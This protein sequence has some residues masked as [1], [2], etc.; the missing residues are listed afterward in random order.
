MKVSVVVPVYNQEV[1]LRDALDSLKAQTLKDI[2]FIIVNDGSTDRSLEIINEYAQGDDRFVVLDQENSGVAA[3]IN[4]GNQIAK[5]EYL[6]EM[7]SDDY[8]AHD[9][10]EIMYNIA[11]SNDLDILKSNVINFTGS[12]ESYKGKVEKIAK[13][14]YYDRVIDP[15]E[16][17][18]VFSFPMYAWVSLYRRT[19]IIDNDI[20]WNDGVS[21]YNDNGFFWQTMCHAKRVMYLDR[22]FIYHRRDNEMSTV[23]NPDKMFSNFFIEHAF[24]KN[25]LKERGFFEDIKAYFFERKINNYYFALTVIPFEKKREFFNLIAKDF[26]SD[27]LDEGLA[28]LTFV[29]KRNLDKILSICSDPDLYYSTVYLPETYKVSVVVPIHNAEGF[30]RATLDKLINQSLRAV[31]FILVE[32]GSTDG[33]NDIIAEYKR[34]DARITAV[35]IGPSN[36]GNARNVGLSMANGQY[37]IFLDAD[38]EYDLKMLEK[39]H[40]AAVAAKAD[41]VW[42]N[43][44]ERNARTGLIKP[45]T[46]AYRKSNFPKGRP[47]AFSEISGNPF[48][49]MIGWPWDKLY[50]MRYVRSNGFYYQDL[51]VSNDGYFNF[52]AMAKAKRIATVD[53]V[54]VT[55]V[56]DH[57]GNISSN[58]HDTNPDNQWKMII[59][60]YEQLK[61]VPD[62]IKI[63][64]AF[65]ERSIRSIAWLFTSGFKTK[66]GATKYFDLLVGGELAKLELDQLAP[67]DV[68]ANRQA[69]WQKL[70]AMES[71]QPGDYD[72]FIAEVGGSDFELSQ[73]TNMAIHVPDTSIQSRAARLIFAQPHSEG[74]GKSKPW[75]NIILGTHDGSN[76]TAVIDFVFLGHSGRVVHDTLNISLSLHRQADGS[77]APVVGQAEWSI[78]HKELV[79]GLLYSYVGNV[80]TIHAKYPSRY[81]GFEYRFRH[82]VSREVVPSFSV[83]NVAMGY[84]T[85][86]L[87]DH[88]G[89]LVSMGKGAQVTEQ[90]RARAIYRGISGDNT[91]MDLLEIELAP[92]AHNNLAVTVEF[93]KIPNNSRISYDTV[94]L[95]F[96]VQP[97]I[98]GAALRV[99]QAELMKGEAAFKKCIYYYVRGNRLVLGGKYFDRWAGYS[100]KVT[101]VIGRGN[102]SD[103]TIRFLAPE[104]VNDPCLAIPEDAVFISAKSG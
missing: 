96:A 26:R 84:D 97:E 88:A 91:G 101:N 48:D 85:G 34:K 14:E 55:R 99:F 102:E 66:E 16:E 29:N 79:D 98:D 15:M 83:V 61:L 24:I 39:A 28:Y 50:S 7:D 40:A 51:D 80:F 35:S 58:K 18:I 56:V 86:L 63:A 65:A 49:C 4:R 95:G 25:R 11:V 38:D 47:F 13:P 100:F 45:H 6:A 30:L 17:K 27:L 93:A 36:A 62:G 74:V 89:D 75:F 67:E 31:E 1:Y 104:I 41:V 92:Y 78:G 22:D 10:Y 19:L 43:T 46:H 3:A 59:G 87:F 53:D 82:V 32:N 20:I 76:V 70:L 57:G 9:M 73:T 77:V 37:V 72:R 71:Y 60:I 52:L 54:L 44:R 81:A 8:V 5:G 42:F 12:G 33:T 21:S 90:A 103:N 23:K 69:I 2:E 68:V 94:C 64:Q